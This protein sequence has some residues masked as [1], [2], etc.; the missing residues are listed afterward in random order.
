MSHGNE[1]RTHTPPSLAQLTARYLERQA[2]A[3]AAGLA[4]P[5]AGGEVVLYEAGPVQPIDART[6]WDEAL[7][8]ARFFN[9]AATTPPPRCWRRMTRRSP[10]SGAPPGPTSRRHWRGTAGSTTRR[11]RR[12]V[13]RRRARRCCSTAAWRPCSAA[14]PPR[15][16]PP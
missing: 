12:G 7:A 13:T 16:A 6:A 4:A 14:T 1:E 11:G 5:D 3:D 15:P 10:P 8:A 2:E 9:P